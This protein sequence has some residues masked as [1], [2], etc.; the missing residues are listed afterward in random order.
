MDYE[1]FQSQTTSILAIVVEA[2]IAEMCR[3]EHEGS[4]MASCSEISCTGDDGDQNANT[5]VG[6]F[7]PSQAQ[8]V[9]IMHLLMK[10]A[11]RKLCR[12][13]RECTTILQNENET[14]KN[15]LEFMVTPLEKGYVMSPTSAMTDGETSASSEEDCEEDGSIDCSIK[16]CDISGINA[17]STS[18]EDVDNACRESSAADSDPPAGDREEWK[19]L[20]THA[21]TRKNMWVGITT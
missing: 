16:E 18:G 21:S 17:T 19:P 13:F 14:L 9:S 10:E 5:G 7:L 15:K 4:I 6:V 8:L 2:A 1:S 11:V 20:K 3:V 12:L